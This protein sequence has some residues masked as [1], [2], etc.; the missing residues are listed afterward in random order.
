M[1]NLSLRPTSSDGIQFWKN[2]T[3]STSAT[4]VT[5]SDFTSGSA[6]NNISFSGSYITTA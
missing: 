3:N 2:A 4:R 6:Y 5:G 1:P